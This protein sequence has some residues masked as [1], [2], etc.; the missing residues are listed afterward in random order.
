MKK[1]I[2]WAIV[3][4]GIIGFVMAIALPL[5]EPE[6]LA[7]GY[8]WGIIIKAIIGGILCLA[9]G[10]GLIRKAKI[11]EYAQAHDLEL[12]SKAIEKADTALAKGDYTDLFYQLNCH[13]CRFADH[14]ARK[15]KEPWC[16]RPEPPEQGDDG[17]CYSREA[18]EY[19]NHQ[20]GSHVF[21]LSN[22]YKATDTD[23]LIN[24]DH[25]FQYFQEVLSCP[26]CAFADQEAR[27]QGKP[28]CNAPNPPDIKNNYCHTWQPESIL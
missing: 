18:L 20:K 13:D 25:D 16:T 2:G 10:A 12:S 11:E 3:A 26:N 27:Q 5:I 8:G 22:I 14:E 7:K 6:G 23:K 1:K 15:R 24:T 21:K 17:R 9:F 19:Y 28:W 4:L